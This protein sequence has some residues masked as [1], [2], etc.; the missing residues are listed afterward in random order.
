LKKP[1]LAVIA[2]A[3]SFF[4]QRGEPGSEDALIQALNAYGD[5]DMAEAFLNRGN[6]ALEAAAR[7]WAVAHGYQV[8]RTTI[9][10]GSPR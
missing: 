9:Q 6:S 3:F 8:I 7:Q 10:L 2:G 5:K 1:D 4:I